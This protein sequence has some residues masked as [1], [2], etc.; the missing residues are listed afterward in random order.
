[1]TRPVPKASERGM[2]RRGS[3]TSPAVKVMLFHASAE[4]KEP[5]CA[6]QKAMNRPKAPAL[7]ATLEI[8]GKSGL[9]GT[10]PRGVQKSPK[11]ALIASALRPN[12][13]PTMISAISDKVLA[14][15]KMFWIHL[16]S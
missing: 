1:M 9:I 16:P 3:F 2:F 10:T 4:N 12:S 15:V 6:T 7:A 5:T 13:K 8:H 11:L 14:E